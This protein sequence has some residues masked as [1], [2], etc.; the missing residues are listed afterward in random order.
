MS[1]IENQ[2]IENLQEEHGF[3]AAISFHSY[4]ELILWPWGYTSSMQTR[5]HAFFLKH[6]TVMGKIMDDYEPIQASDLYAA[7]GIFDDYLYGAHNVAAYT[8]ELG[9]QFVPPQSEVPEINRRGV[10]MLRYVFKN[11]RKKD[12][13]VPYP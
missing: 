1:E 5:D 8:I 11:I 7:S 4:S 2:V 13:H 9:R 3:T 12:V 6:G 10:K